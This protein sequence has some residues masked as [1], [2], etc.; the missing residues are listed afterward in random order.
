VTGDQWKTKKGTVV[1]KEVLCAECYAG[2]GIRV[3]KC[4]V[5]RPLH[6]S[7]NREVREVT[8]VEEVREVRSRDSGR[9]EQTA[10]RRQ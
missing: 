8:E 6:G 4:Y 7:D 1:S 3:K 10:Y 2:K 5:S 9:K